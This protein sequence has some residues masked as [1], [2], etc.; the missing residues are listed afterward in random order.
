MELGMLVRGGTMPKRV[1]H[2]FDRL[3][4]SGQVKQV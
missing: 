4:Q 1:E 3:I 2:Q